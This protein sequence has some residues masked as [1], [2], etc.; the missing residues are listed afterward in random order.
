[1]S[2]KPTYRGVRY[3]S[4]E[5]LYKSVNT[6]TPEQKQQAIQTFTDY[7]NQTGRKDIEG[8]REFVKNN[9]ITKAETSQFDKN[10][11]ENLISNF[12]QKLLSSPIVKEITLK[13]F[14][15]NTIEEAEAAIRIFAAVHG[16]D[17]TKEMLDKCY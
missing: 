2:C 17:K 9:N 7:V 11:I 5:E 8:F 10:N 15:V 3:N 4:L 6:I 12:K 1:M 16:V 14:N 13:A